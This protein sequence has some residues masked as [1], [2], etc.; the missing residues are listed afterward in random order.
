MEI[1]DP[2]VSARQ[3][4]LEYGV[5]LISEPSAEKYDA[6]IVAVNHSCFKD[7]GVRQIRRFGKTN[8]VL[9]DVKWTFSQEETDL[10]L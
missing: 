1:Y 8:H 10:R 2:W 9:Y 7:L 3:A 4:S 5:D 6:I